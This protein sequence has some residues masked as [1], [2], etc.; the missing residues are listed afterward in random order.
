MLHWQWV[1]TNYDLK[2]FSLKKN[3]P[4]PCSFNASINSPTNG[5]FYNKSLMLAGLVSAANWSIVPAAGN[6]NSAAK[7]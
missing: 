1:K 5:T 7:S 6:P 4:V 2:Y 3:I